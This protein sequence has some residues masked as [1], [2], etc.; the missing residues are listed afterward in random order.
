MVKKLLIICVLAFFVSCEKSD[1]VD[2]NKYCWDCHTVLVMSGKT[3][4]WDS[5]LCEMS[6]AEKEDHEAKNTASQPGSEGVTTCTK[7]K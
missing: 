1:T 6:E 3:T 5:R 4:T 2:L 7:V